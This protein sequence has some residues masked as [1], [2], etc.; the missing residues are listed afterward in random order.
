MRPDLGNTRRRFTPQLLSL[1]GNPISACSVRIFPRSPSPAAPARGPERSDA[2]AAQAIEAQPVLWPDQPRRGR[3]RAEQHPRKTTWLTARR[4]CT[5]EPARQAKRK[6]LWHRQRT[7]SHH[8]PIW[9]T[10]VTHR[11][12]VSHAESEAAW[13]KR[14]NEGRDYLSLKLHDPRPRLPTSICSTTRM[15]RAVALTGHATAS[16][17]EPCRSPAYCPTAGGISRRRHRTCGGHG[18]DV[19]VRKPQS[20]NVSDSSVQPTGRTMPSI[21]TMRKSRSIDTSR[22]GRPLD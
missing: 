9:P 10:V 5:R 1:A 3:G 6:K 21:V 12:N 4:S 18:A 14:S 11:F 20:H 8:R 2:I 7:A 19:R 16:L 17:R 22:E 13:S 15:E